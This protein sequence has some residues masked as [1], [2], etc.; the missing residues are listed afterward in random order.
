L[1][2]RPFS[3]VVADDDDVVQIMVRGEVDIAVVGELRR[4][5]EDGIERCVRAVCVDLSD[6][7]HLDSSGLKVLVRANIRARVT[8]K[9]LTLRGA[10][11]PVRRVLDMTGVDRVL[12]ID[13]VGVGLDPTT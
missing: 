12:T 2:I 7:T 3:V 9:E 13:D 8:G 1:V 5:L 11:G 4:A 10:Q 6:V